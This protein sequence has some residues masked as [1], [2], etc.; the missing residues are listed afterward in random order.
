M[1]G[2]DRLFGAHSIH[3]YKTHQA[4]KT[5][6]ICELKRLFQSTDENPLLQDYNKKTPLHYAVNFGTTISKQSDKM[7]NLIHYFQ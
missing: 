7:T 5:G 1:R 3:S 4:A 6:N 2:R